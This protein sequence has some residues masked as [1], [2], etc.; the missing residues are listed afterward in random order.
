MRR[1]E[2]EITRH[3]GD[4]PG[5]RRTG[6]ELQCAISIL[7]LNLNLQYTYA[8]RSL[9]CKTLKT[10]EGLRTWE[11]SARLKDI[12]SSSVWICDFH[13]PDFDMVNCVMTRQYT[14]LYLYINISYLC[15]M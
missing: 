5:S 2:N 6:G 11:P 10:K 14:L 7:D 9:V 4:D 13:F 15:N 12:G 8:L 1:G 3:Q